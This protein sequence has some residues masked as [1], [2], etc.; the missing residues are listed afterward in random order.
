ML[1]ENLIKNG[2]MK[3]NLNWKGDKAFVVED[4]QRYLLLEGS[5]GRTVKVSQK[6]DTE[7]L[8]G[9]LVKFVY[10]SADY[11]GSG[12]RLRCIAAGEIASNEEF[13]IKVDGKWHE[14]SWHCSELLSSFDH[15]LSIELKAG[16]GKV[17]ID[18]V[19]VTAVTNEKN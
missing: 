19:S 16:T 15:T 9:V 8:D 6:F 3:T 13:E 4:D 7:G 2:E 12:L 17:L 18:K 11:K 1:A 14:L 5:S 10:K